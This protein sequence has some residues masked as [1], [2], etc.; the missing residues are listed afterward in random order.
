MYAEGQL[1]ATIFSDYNVEFTGIDKQQRCEITHK[2]NE[3]W[4]GFVNNNDFVNGRGE[5]TRTFDPLVPNQVR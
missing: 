3:P 5:R 4:S 2:L 1:S